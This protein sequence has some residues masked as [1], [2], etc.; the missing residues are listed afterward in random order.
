M[1]SVERARNVFLCSVKEMDSGGESGVDCTDINIATEL[2]EAI[3]LRG[4]KFIN[5]NIPSIRGKLDELN[6]LVSQCPD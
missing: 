4:L 1:Q 2:R 5:Q 6:I 3:K